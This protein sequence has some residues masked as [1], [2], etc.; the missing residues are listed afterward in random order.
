MSAGATATVMVADSLLA[1][2]GV[3]FLLRRAGRILSDPAQLKM[4]QKVIAPDVS[5]TVR[6]SNLG[7]LFEAAAEN[8]SER[9]E[10]TF[11]GG[12]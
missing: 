11:V 2:L 5:A 7:R 10:E 8:V 9:P 12:S 1:S 3:A 4:M 6:R